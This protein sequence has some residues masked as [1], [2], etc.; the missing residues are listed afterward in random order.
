[1]LLNL[2]GSTYWLPYEFIFASKYPF[3]HVSFADGFSAKS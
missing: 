1:M 2:T 3:T